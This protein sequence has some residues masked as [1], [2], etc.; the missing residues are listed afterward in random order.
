MPYRIDGN[1]VEVL[2]SDGW[3]TLKT[4][5]SKKLAE[6]HLKALKLNVKH[7]TPRKRK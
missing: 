2:R 6:R 5:R 3:K 7:T 4:H 1:T